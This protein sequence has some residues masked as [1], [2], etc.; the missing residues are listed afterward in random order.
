MEIE[1][2]SDEAAA[3][4]AVSERT[5]IPAAEIARAFVCAGLF[6]ACHPGAAFVLSLIYKSN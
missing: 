1:L 2:L 4:D 5:G 6:G 3:I